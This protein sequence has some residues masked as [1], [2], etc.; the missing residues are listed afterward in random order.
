MAEVHE[1]FRDAPFMTRRRVKFGECDPAGVVYT[2][3]FADYV[4]ETFLSFNEY[5]L[6]SPVQ[7]RYAEL[8]LGLPGKALR[9]EFKQ[10]LWPDQLFDISVTVDEIRTRTYDLIFR[11]TTP[12]GQAVFDATFTPI[13]IYPATRQGRAIPEHLRRLLQMYRD[14]CSAGLEPAVVERTSS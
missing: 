14:R 1:K 12:E 11:A 4:V 7:S 6:G 9:L 10:G 8:D 2:P 13:C 3:R 5:L